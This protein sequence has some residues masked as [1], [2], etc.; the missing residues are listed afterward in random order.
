MAKVHARLKELGI[1][2]PPAPAPLGAYVP[3][4]QV[5]SL[6]F[7]S[8][9]L[10]R[11][12]G[13]LVTGKLGAE[14][15]LAKAKAAARTAGL[16]GLAA[17]DAAVGLDRVKR[18]VKLTVVV[19]GTPDFTDQPQVANGA[20]ELMVEVFGEAGKHARLAVGAPVLPANACLEVEILAEVE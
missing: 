10:P 4:V 9:Q 17:I 7:V 8:G 18:I 2:L 15:S 20:S 14:V 5:G 16:S 11:V 19:A 13:A 1:T 12:D 3:A 6:L